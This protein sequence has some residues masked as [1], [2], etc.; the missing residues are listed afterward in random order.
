VVSAPRTVQGRAVSPS[1]FLQEAQCQR[2]VFP[3]VARLVRR[4]LA[5]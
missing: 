4:V 3:T 5:D 1:R 2:V